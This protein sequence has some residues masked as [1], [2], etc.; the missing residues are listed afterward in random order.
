[1]VWIRV[2]DDCVVQ[3]VSVNVMINLWVLCKSGDFV[4]SACPGGNIYH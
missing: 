2:T 3:R 4:T 1:M